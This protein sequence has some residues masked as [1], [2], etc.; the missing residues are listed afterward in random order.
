M[1]PRAGR[2]PRSLTNSNV[3][4]P[5][6]SSVTRN[7]SPSVLGGGDFVKFDVTLKLTLA[8]VGPSLGERG[9][10]FSWRASSVKAEVSCTATPVD[11]TAVPTGPAVPLTHSGAYPPSL[12]W[13]HGT[14]TTSC[15][16]AGE[17]T[18]SPAGPLANKV[19]TTSFTYG[20]AV[21]SVYWELR[22]VVGS[23]NVEVRTLKY[24]LQR[25]YIDPDGHPHSTVYCHPAG[26]AGADS[27]H[28]DYGPDLDMRWKYRKVAVP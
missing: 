26:L 5:P 22:T 2:S 4:R 13:S 8:S 21:I 15:T 28:G 20:A 6:R 9:S 19:L 25:M 7:R 12:T 10:S 17:I 23:N 18:Q 3:F 16:P 27:L 24:I 11:S 14:H 1:S